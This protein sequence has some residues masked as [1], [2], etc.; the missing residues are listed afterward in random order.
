ME[1]KAFHG[2]EL[3]R[4][5]CAVTIITWHYQHFFWV[6]GDMAPWFQRSLQPFYTLLWGAYNWGSYAVEVFWGISG[7]IFFWKYAQPVRS[8]QVGARTF[9]NL[10]FSRLYPLHVATL[11]MVVVLQ[12]WYAQG[13]QGTFVYGNHDLRHFVL[14]LAMASDWGLDKGLSFNG[15]VWSVSVEVLAYTAFFLVA[16]RFRFSGRLMAG[17][18]LGLVIAKMALPWIKDPVLCLLY[19]FVGGTAFLIVTRSP[20]HE[21]NL[22]LATLATSVVLVVWNWKTDGKVHTFVWISITLFLVA[23]AVRLGR[24]VVRPS[25]RQ[26][27]SFLGGLTYS[28]Y[29]LH[30]PVQLFAV[31]VADRFEVPRETFLHPAAYLGFMGACFGLASLSYVYFEYPMQQFLR[32]KLRSS[33]RA[34]ALSEQGQGER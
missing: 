27:F 3:L 22:F 4:F 18:I 12:W 19:F 11:V 24:V 29:L 28:S 16:R 34:A 6:D 23:A 9:F 32:R 10:R 31:I 26:V 33:G 25:A 17:L 30:F 2:L 7:F 14:H 20:R 5:L 8:G 1:S 13:H 15:P 21:R